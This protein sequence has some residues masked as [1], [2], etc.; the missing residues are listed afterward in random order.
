MMA[1]PLT[2]C[3]TSGRFFLSF[4][5][6]IS[7]AVII[8]IALIRPC[9]CDR[10]ATHCLGLKHS[11][12]DGSNIRWQSQE[13]SPSSGTSSVVSVSLSWHGTPHHHQPGLP[14]E[15]L[16]KQKILNLFSTFDLENLSNS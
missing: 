1:R 15:K 8:A 13:Q 3:M 14:T 5:F 2:A 7:K 9:L 6:L 11:Q 12:C 4:R 16:S 10:M